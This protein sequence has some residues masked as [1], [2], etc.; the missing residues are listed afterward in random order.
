MRLTLKSLAGEALTN[1]TQSTT[2]LPWL[3]TGTWPCE[4]K[5]QCSSQGQVQGQVPVPAPLV[6]YA[7]VSGWDAY[8]ILI[9]IANWGP[10]GLPLR[11]LHSGVWAS[12]LLVS[13]CSNVLVWLTTA[14]CGCSPQRPSVRRGG[15]LRLASYGRDQQF[16]ARVHVRPS[17]PAQVRDMV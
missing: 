5:H 14:C 7:L 15:L 11:W 2:Q 9:I 1:I 12:G 16:A 13:Q 3:G 4:K 8:T 10:R 17:P 6:R